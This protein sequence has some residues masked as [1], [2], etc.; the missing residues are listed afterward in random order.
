MKFRDGLVNIILMM[1]VLVFGM[2]VWGVLSGEASL[3]NKKVVDSDKVAE[4]ST[5]VFILEKKVENLMVETEVMD[6][7]LKVCVEK[8]EK[9]H[10]S[11]K[12][13]QSTRPTIRLATGKVVQIPE[14]M[15]K[16]EKC[17]GKG[18]AVVDIGGAMMNLVQEKCEV[19][20]GRGFVEEGK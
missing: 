13:P 5:R 8:L 10:L 1:I 6:K 4:L 12:N 14:G 11:E 2:F 16:C 19:C 3:K 18:C 20:D 17:R 7:Y 9:N 15:K